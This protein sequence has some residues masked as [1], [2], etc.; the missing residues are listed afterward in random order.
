MKCIVF[1]GIDR[2]Y[3]DFLHGANPTLALEKDEYL[4]RQGDSGAGMYVVLQ[5]KLEVIL[6]GEV[7]NVVAVIEAGS[8]LGEITMLIH[9]NRTAT[10]KAKEKSSLFYL[11]AEVFRKEIESENINA[12]KIAYN[13]SKVLAQRLTK[14]NE[15][16]SSL[17]MKPESSAIKREIAT[18]RDLLLSE[19]LL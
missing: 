14:T 6:D 1:K 17:Q 11:D 4:F 19:V 13:I 3:I 7:N 9:H 2:S 15:M 8:F 12:L 10:V 5:G 18:F 16:I